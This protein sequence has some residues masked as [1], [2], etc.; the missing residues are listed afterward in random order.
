MIPEQN[1]RV[2][3]V[4]AAVLVAALALVAGMVARDPQLQQKLGMP[5]PAVGHIVLADTEGGMHPLDEWNGKVRLVN[6]WGTFCP[7]CRKEIPILVSLQDRYGDD[8]LQVIGV[9][10]DTDYELLM[11][12]AEQRGVNYPMLVGEQS[13][14]D[15][16]HA[17]GAEFIGLP[18]TVLIDREGH[19]RGIH[20]GD[21][22]AEAESRESAASG[23]PKRR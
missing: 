18:F 7:P 22:D 23:N 5:G 20:Y 19:V 3:G 12:Y 11:A 1:H 16:A 17:M 14:V 9:S 8:G 6:F 4:T 2:L 10:F 15:A 13:A 21:M